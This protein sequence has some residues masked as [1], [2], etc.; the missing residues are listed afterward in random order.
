MDEAAVQALLASLPG[1]QRDALARG[2]RKGRRLLKTVGYLVGESSLLSDLRSEPAVADEELARLA[3]PTL[4]IFGK[5]SPCLPAGRRL[6]SVVSGFRLHVASGGHFLPLEAPEELAL[7][8]EG[9]LD[10]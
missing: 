7:A 1:S 6:E 4:G 8:I 9:F 10:G 3:P 2:R 5:D